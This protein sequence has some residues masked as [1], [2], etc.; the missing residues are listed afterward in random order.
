MFKEI[1]RAYERGKTNLL[2]LLAGGI[3]GALVTLWITR[4]RN[5]SAGPAMSGAQ[6]FRRL[7]RPSESSRPQPRYAE[8]VSQVVQSGIGNLDDEVDDPEVDF[9]T[10]GDF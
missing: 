9:D 4:W 3:T 2:F 8:P 6:S 1:V 7:L 10:P 5:P